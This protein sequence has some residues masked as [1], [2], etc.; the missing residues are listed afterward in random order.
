VPDPLPPLNPGSVLGGRFRL[1]SR[2]GAGA[3]AAVWRAR[4]LD[5]GRVVAVKALLGDDVDPALAGRF[6]REG[7]LLGRLSHPNVVPVHCT[8]NEGGRPYLVMDLVDGLSLRDVLADGPLPVEDAVRLAADVAD[9]LAAA[10]R[11]GGVHRDVKPANVIC[12][13]DGVPRLVDFGIARADDL[14]VMTQANVVLGTAAYL[15]PEQARGEAVGPPSDVYS[16]GCLLHELLAGEPPF[17]GD[18]PLAVAYKHVHEEP[19]PLPADVP[20]AVAGVVARCLAKDPAARYPDG[21][22]LAAD[23]RRGAHD[24]DATVAV[25]AVP[26]PP[27]RTMVMPAVT[28]TGER[29]DPSPLAAPAER[30]RWPLVAGIAAAA[31]VLSLLAGAAFGDSGG[32]PP[33]DAS[34]D[35]PATTTTTTTITTTTTTTAAPPPA[36]TPAQAGKPGKGKGKEKKGKD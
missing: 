9:G 14:T 17:R 2:L 27:N 21:A 3:T 12:G 34:E 19:P 15:S 8:G 31:L 5:L 6:E 1:E 16:L 10:H 32:T 13:A 35:A 20:A 25:A 7:Q 11:A 18:G 30:R 28:P 26:V 33:A 29:I 36:P 23:L 4:D 22:A 24:G